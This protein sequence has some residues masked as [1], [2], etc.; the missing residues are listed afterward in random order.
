MRLTRPAMHS[1]RIPIA[2]AIAIASCTVPLLASAQTYGPDAASEAQAAATESA[3]ARIAPSPQQKSAQ[4]KK[5]SMGVMMAALIESAERSAHQRRDA[6]RHAAALDETRP[7]ASTDA[8]SQQD[9]ASVIPREGA[10]REQVAV[11]DDPL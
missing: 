10:S 9:P 6:A 11:Q 4:P 7:S 8:V 1:F 3:S 5:S 2:T